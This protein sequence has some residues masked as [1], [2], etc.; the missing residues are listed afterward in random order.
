MEIITD[1]IP[2]LNDMVDL[3][4]DHDYIYLVI[5]AS[6]TSL[7]VTKIDKSDPNV[8]KNWEISGNFETQNREKINIG[9][10]QDKGPL[11]IRF[12]LKDDN[13]IFSA[14]GLIN[15]KV[16]C[17]KTNQKLI[18]EISDFDF[19]VIKTHFA[20][21]ILTR[22]LILK[23]LNIIQLEYKRVEENFNVVQTEFVLKTKLTYMPSVIF[24]KD[25]SLEI[26]GCIAYR[27]EGTNQYFTYNSGS[28][29]VSVDKSLYFDS[30]LGQNFD[31]NDEIF[32]R[33]SVKYNESNTPMLMME[34]WDLGDE[35]LFPVES[36][37]M[38]DLDPNDP[39]F[40]LLKNE[41]YGNF[42]FSK[43]LT[44]TF[45]TTQK[46]TLDL[47]DKPDIEK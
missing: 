25:F 15:N 20:I 38:D 1:G 30:S 16:T 10:T 41:K 4:S 42:L 29:S 46:M 8:I 33:T 45:K 11:I 2:F 22:S 17:L 37:P 43:T 23:Q 3:V 47:T 6:T 34:I 35:S 7:H 24:C 26:S 40:V 31:F 27:S 14:Y 36:P 9:L 5:K 12:D 28:R 21:Q 39:N 13:W 18:T 19:T 44:G 32:L